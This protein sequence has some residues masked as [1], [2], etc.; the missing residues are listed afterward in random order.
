MHELG[1]TEKI[2][3]LVLDT[4]AANNA[5]RITVIRIV[6]GELSG[7]VTTAVAEYFGIIAKD[8]PAQGARLKFTRAP[9]RLFCSSCDQEFQKRP[10]DFACPACGRV[11]RLGESGRECFVT[12]I[13]VDDDGDSD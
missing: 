13:E 9:A 7:I 1:I 8:T 4:A 10:E 12:S 3:K 6:V 5:G 11:G 2:L